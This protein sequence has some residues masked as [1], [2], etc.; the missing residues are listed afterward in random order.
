MVALVLS[1][2]RAA[3]RQHERDHPVPEAHGPRVRTPRA[4]THRELDRGRPGFLTE[5]ESWVVNL[6]SGCKAKVEIGGILH[7]SA[8]TV[9]YHPPQHPRKM[10]PEVR[11]EIAARVAAG[12]N[13][14]YPMA[15]ARRS[16]AA[17]ATEMFGTPREH[18]T[19]RR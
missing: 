15:L 14:Y 7:I 13:T 10:R 2:G 4:R 9:E 16:L 19:S 1:S 5:R 11:A 8:R 6:V 3:A 12:P 18:R 17:S